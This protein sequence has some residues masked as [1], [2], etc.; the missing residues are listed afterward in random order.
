MVRKKRRKTIDELLGPEYLE[1]HR[2]TQRML[3][4]RIEYH[5]RKLAEEQVRQRRTGRR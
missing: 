1:S 2:R 5:E 4:A 3:A